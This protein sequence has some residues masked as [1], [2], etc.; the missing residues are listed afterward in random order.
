MSPRFK[1][2]PPVAPS[3]EPSVDP[4]RAVSDDTPLVNPVAPVPTDAGPSL[5]RDNAGAPLGPQSLEGKGYMGALAT[6]PPP[7]NPTEG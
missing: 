2:T 4:R 7:L 3:V 1:S 6:Q 5:Y